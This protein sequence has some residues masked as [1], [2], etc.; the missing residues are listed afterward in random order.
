MPWLLGWGSQ[1]NWIVWSITHP[2]RRRIS[3]NWKQMCMLARL[4]IFWVKKRGKGHDICF[5]FLNCHSFVCDLHNFFGPLF[6]NSQI[7]NAIMH[8]HHEMVWYILIKT[9]GDLLKRYAIRWLGIV[10]KIIW[11]FH[12]KN[13]NIIA[14]VKPEAYPFMYSLFKIFTSTLPA[15][16]MQYIYSEIEYTNQYT[17]DY[18]YT[19]WANLTLPHTLGRH[20]DLQEMSIK[21]EFISP[22]LCQSFPQSCSC[23]L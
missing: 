8:K 6:P 17:T 20:F 12:V 9:F 5:F 10:R 19:P 7:G 18:I 13:I 2:A 4:P 21:T 1:N 15:S 11:G 14:V 16:L 3:L 23:V 22:F